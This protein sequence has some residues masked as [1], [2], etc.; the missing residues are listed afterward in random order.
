M[1]ERFVL[2]MAGHPGSGKST[3]ARAIGEAT[4]AAVLDKDVL[5]TGLLDNGIDEATAAP[6]AYEL[7]FRTARSLTEQGFSVVLDSPAY[8]P[9]ILENGRNIADSTGADYYV[10]ECA[11]ADESEL[12]RRLDNRIRVASQSTVTVLA[13]PYALPGAKPLSVPHLTIDMSGTLN[14]CLAE[15]LRYIRR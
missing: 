13:D 4:G 3:L 15:A 1:S 10:I 9:E 14:G 6:L 11:V 5:K 8:Y 2:Q 7:F 12:Q